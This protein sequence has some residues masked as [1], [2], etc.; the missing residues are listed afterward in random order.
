MASDDFDGDDSLRRGFA[1][2]PEG[3]KLCHIV[4]FVA[5]ADAEFMKLRKV[6][7]ETDKVGGYCPA[8]FVVS[9]RRLKLTIFLH[10]RN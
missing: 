6:I 2:K 3:Q 5:Q 10:S 9:L 4:G 8:A 1:E 7:Q